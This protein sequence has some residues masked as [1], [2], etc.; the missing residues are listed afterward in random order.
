MDMLKKLFPFSFNS[1][2]TLGSLIVNIIIYLVVG[3]IPG[4][5]MGILKGIPLI[6]LFVGIACA[7]IDLYVVVGAILSVLDYLGVLK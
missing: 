7:V 5:L 3:A 1:K 2:K 6:G 4:A